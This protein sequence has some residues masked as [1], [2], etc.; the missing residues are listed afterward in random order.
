MLIKPD[1]S[2]LRDGQLSAEENLKRLYED[3]EMK[4]AK[5]RT[6]DHDELKDEHLR[7]GHKIHH[8]EFLHKLRK[9]IPGL[10]VYPGNIP[11]TVTLYS[12]RNN[13]LKYLAASFELG[14]IP[15]FTFIRVDRADL[16]KSPLDGGIVHGWRTVLL[17][18]L[19]GKVVSWEDV[20]REFG[21][22]TGASS[23]RWRQQ[24]QAFR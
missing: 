19:K 5:Y 13:E 1:S 8:S 3:T 24:T 17:R 4:V 23:T 2:L 16:M 9:L 7:S 11:N 22:A 15:E 6:H 14:W 18:L 10:Y 20:K 21:D 12:T